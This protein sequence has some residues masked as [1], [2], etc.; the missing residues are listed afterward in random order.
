ERASQETIQ[1]NDVYRTSNLHDMR[2]IERDGVDPSIIILSLNPFWGEG[3]G[4]NS[5]KSYIYMKQ[6]LLKLMHAI[7]W[8]ENNLGVSI[9]TSTFTDF[10]LYI[11]FEDGTN[12]NILILLFLDFYS[13]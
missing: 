4:L 7:Q 3:W 13:I 10:F 11:F 12:L 1:E 8:D 2:D 9:S 6:E 5:E